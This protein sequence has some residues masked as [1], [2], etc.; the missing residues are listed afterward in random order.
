MSFTQ[1]HYKLKAYTWTP[2]LITVSAQYVPQVKKEMQM[3][4]NIVDHL[5]RNN[6]EGV[7]GRKLLQRKYPK[8]HS[9]S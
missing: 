5:S 8:M 4:F 6:E 3:D 7:V 9:Y 2:F 1:N